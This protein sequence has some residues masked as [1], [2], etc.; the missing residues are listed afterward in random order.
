MQI[1]QIATHHH[2]LVVAEHQVH[3][4]ASLACLRLQRVQ[5]PEDFGLVWPAIE[6]V[7]QD[8]EPSLA[9]VPLERTVH[10]AMR[11]QHLHQDFVFAMGIGDHEQRH[12]AFRGDDLGRERLRRA[13]ASP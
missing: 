12:V 5:Q 9:E 1:A 4:A 2:G 11:A 7:A 8:H 3:A 13:A 10:D 6:H